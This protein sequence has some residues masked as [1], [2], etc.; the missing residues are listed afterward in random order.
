MKL[1]WLFLSAESCAISGICKY[2]YQSESYMIVHLLI[3]FHSGLCI[4]LRGRLRL[5]SLVRF[6]LVLTRLENIMLTV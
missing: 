3:V 5:V 4:F 2:L 1:I 6:C